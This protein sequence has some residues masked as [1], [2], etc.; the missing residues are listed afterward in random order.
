MVTT[1]PSWHLEKGQTLVHLCFRV[2]NLESASAVG[3]RLVSST[4]R[5]RR[6]GI[7]S[8]RIAWVFSRKFGL[9]KWWRRPMM[10]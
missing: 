8:S 10:P 6:T 2:P 1:L 4:A 5:R 3:K 7:E 9:S